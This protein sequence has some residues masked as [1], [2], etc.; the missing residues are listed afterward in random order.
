[1]MSVETGYEEGPKNEMD[2]VEQEIRRVR[3]KSVKFEVWM[4]VGIERQKAIREFGDVFKWGIGTRWK[5]KGKGEWWERT[6]FV[7]SLF[8]HFVSVAQAF[9]WVGIFVRTPHRTRMEGTKSCAKHEW[10]FPWILGPVALPVTLVET[11]LLGRHQCGGCTH[12][13]KQERPVPFHSIDCSSATRWSERLYLSERQHN[14]TER[15]IRK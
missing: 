10:I 11:M 14:Q 9:V 5:G 8:E 2:E 3:W 4:K 7:T 6:E 15:R 1:M 13:A 12:L